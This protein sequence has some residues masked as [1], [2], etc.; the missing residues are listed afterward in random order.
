MMMYSTKQQYLLI[1]FLLGISSFIYAKTYTGTVVPL[2]SSNIYGG[3]AASYWGSLDYTARPGAITKPEISDTDNNPI[4]KGTTL[5]SMKE[6]YWKGQVTN[7]RGQLLA[8]KKNLTISYNEYLRYKKLAPTGAEP[9]KFY[10]EMRA[11]FFEAI[12]QLQTAKSNY[13]EQLRVLEECRQVSPFEGVVDKVYY[14]SGILT[15]DPKVLNLIQLNPIGIQVK[16]PADEANSISTETPVTIYVE[17]LKEP[18]GIYNYQTVVNNNSVIF[19]TRN[20]PKYYTN[21]N[22][23]TIEK[24][25]PVTNFY[26]DSEK[27]LGVPAL[28]INKDKNGYFVWRAKNNKVMQP[29]KGFSPVFKTEKVYITPGKYKSVYL[30][31]VQMQLIENPGKLQINDM[32]FPDS[33]NALQENE[34]VSLQPNRYVLMPGD[35]VKVKIGKINLNNMPELAPNVKESNNGSKPQNSSNKDLIFT[36]HSTR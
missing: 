20:T 1:F 11:T 23:K 9:I 12:G 19:Q 29:G 35:T 10:Q 24:Y 36:H 21:K 33:N 7:A 5:V 28:T 32:V 27:Y 6:Q 25:Y 8:A 15:S 17:G 13:L 2:F 31:T 30:G 34:T 22:V 14:S 18:L 4:E 3:S 16:M 26:P